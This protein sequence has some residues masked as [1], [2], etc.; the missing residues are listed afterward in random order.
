MHKLVETTLT[1]AFK[2][3]I[4]VVPKHQE[5]LEARKLRTDR[6]EMMIDD[7]GKELANVKD[8]VAAV[9]KAGGGIANMVALKANFSSL[10]KEVAALQS[11]D[12]GTLWTG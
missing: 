5:L 8:R 7:H 9:K 2:P 1:K 10:K 11:R 6:L 4:E 3:Y 12:C